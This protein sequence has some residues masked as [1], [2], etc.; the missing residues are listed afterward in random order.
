[1]RVV[2]TGAENHAGRDGV[3]AHALR[4]EFVG[5][6]ACK[7]KNG[8]FRRRVD[9]R[10]G[11]TAFAAGERGQVDDA[12]AT[13]G[14]CSCYEMGRGGSRDAVTAA[15]IERH[16]LLPEC[17]VGLGQGLARHQRAGVVD[18][19]IQSAEKLYS[20]ADDPFAF[21][22][23]REISGSVSVPSAE[24]FRFSLQAAGGIGAA[25]IVN[26]YVAAGWEQLAAD[27][28]TDTLG[29][30]GNEGAFAAKFMHGETGDVDLIVMSKGVRRA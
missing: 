22:R 6:G 25:A 26:E 29:A 17:L 7:R 4:T 16:D 1:M 20:F 11:M 15:K 18:Q 5:E 28:E 8:A 21:G 2:K 23:F 10:A 24:R 30:G 9:R 12:G 13:A 27:S 14:L 3:D 19:H